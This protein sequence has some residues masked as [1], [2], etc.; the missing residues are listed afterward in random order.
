[1]L[2]P[3]GLSSLFG[4]KTW[5]PGSPSE[6]CPGIAD[7]THTS[8]GAD[9]LPLCKHFLLHQQHQDHWGHTISLSSSNVYVIV[10]VFECIGI[11]NTWSFTYV[12]DKSCTVLKN[13]PLGLK[14]IKSD[15]WLGFLHQTP[16]SLNILLCFIRSIYSFVSKLRKDFV[17]CEVSLKD[18]GSIPTCV[19]PF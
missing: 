10:N 14:T 5:H 17:L 15:M 16:A 4:A 13:L 3:K 9:G 2:A 12:E 1:M 11:L 7:T 18:H 19:L 6:E 8:S